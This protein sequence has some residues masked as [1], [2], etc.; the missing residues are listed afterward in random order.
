[1]ANG[2]WLKKYENNLIK[3]AGKKK[4]NPTMSPAQIYAKR[5][6]DKEFEFLNEV[7]VNVFKKNFELLAKTIADAFNSADAV[8][9]GLEIINFRYF[10][11]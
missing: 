2:R 7:S 4:I 10:L 11:G 8:K 3:L 5:L 1:M 6:N 9:S